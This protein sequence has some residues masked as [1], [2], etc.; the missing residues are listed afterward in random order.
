MKNQINRAGKGN[1]WNKKKKRKE[2]WDLWLVMCMSHERKIDMLKFHTV[3]LSLIFHAHKKLESVWKRK[4]KNKTMSASP[5]IHLSLL[6]L[7]LNECFGVREWKETE[8]IQPPA[9]SNTVSVVMF[10]WISLGLR[11]SKISHV[12][13]VMR[14]YRFVQ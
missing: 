11:K 3:K 10:L 9:I 7:E 13:P 8:L 6:S 4:E 5:K 1:K 12:E 2:I 14:G